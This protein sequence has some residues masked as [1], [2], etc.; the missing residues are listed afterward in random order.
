MRVIPVRLRSVTHTHTLVVMGQGL[1]AAPTKQA[2]ADA[3]K[4]ELVHQTRFWRVSVDA[5]ARRERRAVDALLA[6]ITAAQLQYA[7]VRG[8]TSRRIAVDM[9]RERTQSLHAAYIKYRQTR[10]S[11][12]IVGQRLAAVER[13]E[14]LIK[15]RDVVRAFDEHDPE[16]A[17]LER[18]I[19]TLETSIAESVERMRK[20]GRLSQLGTDAARGDATHY[21]SLMEEAAPTVDEEIELY[22]ALLADAQP[23]TAPAAAAAAAE[24]PRPSPRPMPRP[25]QPTTPP[26]VGQALDTVASQLLEMMPDVPR[27]P[28]PPRR[29]PAPRQE[30]AK[31]RVPA[32]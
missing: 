6:E 25:V 28:P 30:V 5:Q 1:G 10:Q 26:A 23:A 18:D 27:D 32:T 12:A 29:R 2:V 13:H 19:S 7:N 3:A 21:A 31:T 15:V 4:D 11:L 16:L 14:E 8:E 20:I 22:E 24:A 17:T 9:I